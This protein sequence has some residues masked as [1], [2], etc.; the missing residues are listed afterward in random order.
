[1]TVSSE[2]LDNTPSGSGTTRPESVI[3]LPI[4]SAFPVRGV[5]AISPLRRIAEAD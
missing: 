2:I 5:K 4:S 1:M 3:G